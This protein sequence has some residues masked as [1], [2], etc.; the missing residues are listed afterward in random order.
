MSPRIALWA[1]GLP[2]PTQH[3]YTTAWR[4]LILIREEMVPQSW[5]SPLALR[6][7]SLPGPVYGLH[8]EIAII[9]GSVMSALM[10]VIH[11]R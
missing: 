5:R 6:E 4:R 9:E 10:S 1:R 3:P 8:N 11:H 7:E 2:S